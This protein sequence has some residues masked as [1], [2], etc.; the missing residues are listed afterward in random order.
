MPDFRR[1]TQSFARLRDRLGWPLLAA[2]ATA[3]VIVIALTLI[4]GDRTMAEP[5]PAAP[6]AAP[7]ERPSLDDAQSTRPANKPSP[8]IPKKPRRR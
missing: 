3:V 4:P 7:A 8:A 2:I 5:A 6:A 1:V